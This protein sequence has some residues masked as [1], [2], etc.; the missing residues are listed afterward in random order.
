MKKIYHYWQEKIDFVNKLALLLTGFALPISVTAFNIFLAVT[1][2]LF[3]I[4]GNW[5]EKLRALHNPVFY[6]AMFILLIL[7]LSI[8]Y[9]SANWQDISISLQKYSKLLYL[10]IFMPLFVDEQWKRRGINAFLL[11]MIVT[12]IFSYAKMFKLVQVGQAGLLGTIFTNHIITSFMM[13]FATF[14][15]GYRCLQNTKWRW[16]YIVLLLM[17]LF[18]LFFMNEGRTGILIFFG[19]IIL[20]LWQQFRW[21][22]II[23]AMIAVPILFA[24]LLLFSPTL[25]HGV[26]MIQKDKLDY[27]QQRLEGNSTGLR[28]IFTK[29]SL[30]LI[31]EHPLVGTGVGSFH[32]EYKNQFPPAP[33]FENM[34]EPQNEYLMIAVQLGIIGLL[35][36][37]ALF[38]IEWRQS[39]LLP[40]DLKNLAQGMIVAF[41]IGSVCDTFLYHA[42]TG[43]FFVYFSGLFFANKVDKKGN[44]A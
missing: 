10:I 30:Q 14:I 13:A 24:I 22:G 34:H 23:T 6:I 44:H 32:M 20:F 17:F 16:G 36:F 12:L 9:S 4:G 43:Y 42:M 11:A 25:R 15:I 18:H 5:H 1:M 38:Y 37:L 2:V 8:P 7:L 28:W 26:M 19:L 21:K 31:K 29:N 41:L 40:N 27:Q 35:V 33:G 3:I 39:L